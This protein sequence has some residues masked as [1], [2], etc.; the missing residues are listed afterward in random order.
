MLTKIWDESRTAF[1]NNKNSILVWKK[2]RLL[3]NSLIMF[4]GNC[5]SYM[6]TKIDV[7]WSEFL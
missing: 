7:I 1:E 6:L 3:R 2:A 4:V 5:L